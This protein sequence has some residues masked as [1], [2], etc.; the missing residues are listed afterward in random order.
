MDSAALVRGGVHGEEALLHSYRPP[1]EDAPAPHCVV[2][3]ELTL[4]HHIPA[5]QVGATT[6]SRM[7]SGVLC[8]EGVAAQHRQ[9]VQLRGLHRLRGAIQQR[10]SAAGGHPQ[11]GLPREFPS[12]H[13]AIAVTVHTLAG[14]GARFIPEEAA[15]HRYPGTQYITGFRRDLAL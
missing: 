11:N 13:H 4:T 6:L 9:A 10:S 7:R 8:A 15:P 3:R 14:P 12:L 5:V 2:P 1:R